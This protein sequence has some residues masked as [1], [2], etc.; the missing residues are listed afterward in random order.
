MFC[1]ECGRMNPDEEVLCKG[2]GAQLHQENEENNKKR[3][4]GVGIKI[5]SG[6]IALLIAAGIVAFSTA[7]CEKDTSLTVPQTYIYSEV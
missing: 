1:P 3:K 6:I 5:A 4:S 2:C 7:S